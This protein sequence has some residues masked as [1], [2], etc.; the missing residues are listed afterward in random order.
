MDKETGRIEAFSDGVFAIAI[1]LLVLDVKVP[2]PEETTRLL[3][4]LLAQWPAYGA[5]L[6]S[7]LTILIMWM[8]HHAIFKYVRRSDN[9]FLLLNGLLLLCV[10]L[11]PFPTALLSAYIE[12]PGDARVAAVVYCGLML[13]MAGAFHLVWRYA[14]T[15]GRLLAPDYDATF[16]TRLTGQYR[17]GPALYVLT[18]ALAFVSVPLSIGLCALLAL[19][20][21]L[22]GLRKRH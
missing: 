9:L 1:T 15:N 13:C 12:R 16:V 7:F 10:T 18:F 8:N 2:K 3:P 17:F 22:P 6:V 14:S 21:T 4:A 11:I 19:F 5:F 20:F